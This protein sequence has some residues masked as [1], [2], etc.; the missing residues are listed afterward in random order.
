LPSSE[1]ACRRTPGFAYEFRLIGDPD[2]ELFESL[3]S[4]VDIHEDD[5]A[6]R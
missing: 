5:L 4:S 1:T 3:L 2:P 6:D